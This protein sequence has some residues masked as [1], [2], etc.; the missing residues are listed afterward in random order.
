MTK[1]ATIYRMVFAKHSCPHGVKAKYLLQKHGYEVTDRWLTDRE[2]TD[3]F[4]AQNNVQSTPQIYIDG[5][6]IGGHDDLRRY[7]G[8]KVADPSK[9]TYRPIIAL[10]SMT[11]LLALA[12]SY[13]ATGS[14][15][16]IRAGEWFIAFSMV[17]LAILKLQDI[18]RFSTMFLNYDLLAKKWV[19]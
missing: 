18:G 15:L 19:P 4:K 1:E 7:L 8:L 16:T 14:A 3:T 2:Q 5:Q 11:A 13:A 17:M 6:R 10:F 12:V 9:P